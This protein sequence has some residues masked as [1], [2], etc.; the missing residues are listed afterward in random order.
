MSLDY[1]VK[2]IAQIAGP[3]IGVIGLIKH[4]SYIHAVIFES[5]YQTPPETLI[6]G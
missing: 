3:L 5:S 2:M 6:V 1:I 4:W